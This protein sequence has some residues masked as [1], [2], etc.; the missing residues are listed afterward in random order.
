MMFENLEITDKG[1]LS[2][3][4]QSCCNNVLTEHCRLNELSNNAR[5]GDPLCNFRILALLHI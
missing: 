5:V 1:R 3:G 4:N 2:Y